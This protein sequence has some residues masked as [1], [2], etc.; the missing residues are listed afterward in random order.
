M[1]ADGEKRAE[2][3]GVGRG[4]IVGVTD[5]GELIDIELSEVL[6]VPKLTTGLVSVGVLAQKGFDV[7]FNANGCEVRKRNGKV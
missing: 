7:A 1:L 3:A 6:Y 4:I 2:V 5:T